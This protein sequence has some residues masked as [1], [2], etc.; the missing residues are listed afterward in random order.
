MRSHHLRVAGDVVES[1]RHLQRERV[2]GF[3]PQELAE[4]RLGEF[5]VAGEHGRDGRQV[6]VLALVGGQAARMGQHRLRRPDA[7]HVAPADPQVGLQDVR[8]HE[9]R[10]QLEGPR[11]RGVDRAAPRLPGAERLLVFLRRLW[12]GAARFTSAFIDWVHGVPAIP[13]PRPVRC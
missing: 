2:A 11:E 5:V 8:H 7:S 1:V 6:P 4:A 12:G 3:T 9:A 13:A 10:R